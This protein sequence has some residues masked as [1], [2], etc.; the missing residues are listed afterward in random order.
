[1]VIA[2]LFYEFFKIHNLNCDYINPTDSQPIKCQILAL[3]SS[4]NQKTNYNYMYLVIIFFH[5]PTVFGFGQSADDR[6]ICRPILYS[7]DPLIIGQCVGQLSPASKAILFEKWYQE[8]SHTLNFCRE[9]LKTSGFALGFQHF[10]KP[11]DGN[12]P[13]YSP[14][15]FPCTCTLLYFFPSADSFWV[16]AISR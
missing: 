1:M 11:S 14:L 3:F 6:L 8:A 15:V 2:F 10:F 9:V 7:I 16:L 4:A 12:I 13:E 5:R